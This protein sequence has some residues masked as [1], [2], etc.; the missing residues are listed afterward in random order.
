MKNQAYKNFLPV[1]EGS[2]VKTKNARHLCEFLLQED[3]PV[4]TNCSYFSNHNLNDILGG[5]FGILFTVTRLP[6][7]ES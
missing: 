5:V 3:S 6:C 7:V 2:H 1:L 4:K